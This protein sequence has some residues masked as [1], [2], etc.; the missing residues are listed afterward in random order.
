M[1][2][3]WSSYPPVFHLASAGLFAIVVFYAYARYKLSYWSRRGVK[4]PP[5]H[6]LFGN[7][8]NTFTLKKPPG[9][10]LQDIYESAEDNDSP[11]VGFY[12][13]HSPKLLLRDLKLM[14]QLMVKEFETFPNRCFGGAQQM[15]SVGLVNLLGIHQ[16]RWRYLRQ[17]L[18]PSVTGLKLRAMT[19]L[20]VKCSE[21]MLRFFDEAKGDKDSAWR[22]FEFKD[23]ASRYTTDVIASLAFGIDTDSFDRSKIAFFEAGQKIL[24]G[25]KRGI[26]VIILFY[27]PGLIKFVENFM[28]GPAEYFRIVFGDSI[29]RREQNNAKRNDLVDHFIGL[30]NGEQRPD[31]IFEGDNLLSQAVAFYVAGFEATSTA[32]AFTLHELA[33]HPEYE[34]RLYEEIQVHTAGK[35]LTADLINEM[36]FLDL[37]VNETLRMYPPLPMVDRVPVRDYKIPGTNVTI[38]KGTPIYISINGTNRD[39]KHYENPNEFIPTRPRI[40]SDDLPSSSLSFGMGPRSCIGQRLGLLMTKIAIVTILK[41]YELSNETKGETTLRPVTV[42]TAAADGVHIKLRKRKV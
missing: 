13:F 7:F 14:K 39:P 1:L 29:R 42:F 3:S 20:I 15:D 9:Q 17:K 12:I 11:F 2:L 31:Y 8:G 28:V 30:K 10:E 4:S 23:V 24:S 37:V 40:E 27:V 26:I 22:S 19:P 5:T 18:A 34:N 38:E 41:E 25:L 32:I 6:W 21:P 16:P 33:R 36:E 35:E